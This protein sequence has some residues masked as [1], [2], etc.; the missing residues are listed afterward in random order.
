MQNLQTSVITLLFPSAAHTQMIHIHNPGMPPPTPNPTPLY[1][2]SGHAPDLWQVAHWGLHSAAA[3]RPEVWPLVMGLWG[4]WGLVGCQGYAMLLCT[5]VN[6]LAPPLRLSPPTHPLLQT[7]L[8]CLPTS[9]T[10]HCNEAKVTLLPRLL[11]H[12]REHGVRQ[13]RWGGLLSTYKVGV[14]RNMIVS[15]VVRVAMDWWRYRNFALVVA[16]RNSKYVCFREI[17]NI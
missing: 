4:G 6:W 7:P 11:R 8:T 17:A 14:R 3:S 12:G 10:L 1:M 15:L 2:Y 9:P 13:Y 16:Y 5:L